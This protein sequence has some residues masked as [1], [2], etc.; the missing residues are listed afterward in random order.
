MP[1]LNKVARDRAVRVAARRI[2][3]EIGR[4]SKSRVAILTGLPRSEV[5]RILKSEDPASVPQPDQHRA[6]RVLAGWHE[7]SVFLT[8][9]GLPADLP[10]FGKTRSFQ[11]L[12]ARH[13]GGIPVR[14]M[15]DELTRL[16][17]VE[18][19]E[20]MKVR[21]IARIPIQTGL[22]NRSITTLGER[23]SELLETLTHNIRHATQPMFEATAFVAD[24]DMNMI[25]LTRQA[26]TERGE[27]FIR[28]AETLL[29]RSRAKT[30]VKNDELCR[31]GVTVYYFQ[32]Q[33]KGEKELTGKPRK[34]LRRMHAKAV[35]SKP[36]A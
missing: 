28:D 33:A 24:A 21:A 5:G 27:K 13:G 36:S 30:K 29:H 35:K 34:N 11:N 17:A 15:L 10:I 3:Q 32:D 8:A 25:S 6:R 1:E 22:T 31:L 18:Q 23:A 7:S 19:I 2:K 16:N 14:A 26:I 20:G 12:V 4:D 9:N